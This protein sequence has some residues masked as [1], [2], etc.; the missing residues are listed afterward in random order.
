MR[1]T[2]AELSCW[3]P[4]ATPGPTVQ[5][6]PRTEVPELILDLPVAPPLIERPGWTTGRVGG[7]SPSGPT[8]LAVDR[9]GLLYL[10][11]Q[12]RLRVIVYDRGRYIREIPLLYVSP[13]SQG[14]LVYADRLY[15]T[16]R[17][18]V[19]SSEPNRMALEHEIDLATGRALRIALA[20]R[21]A[22]IYPRIR[23]YQPKGVP[24]LRD[25]GEDALGSRYQYDTSTSIH[26]FRR[27][28]AA[29]RA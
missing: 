26:V 24:P 8:S 1:E 25:L 4:T 28:D 10:W 18:S 7:I 22:S 15:L 16:D 13:D 3:P 14:L 23:V 12:A 17:V 11:D 6:P 29:G 20:D 21:A 2:R 9:D 19:A 27:L 5:P